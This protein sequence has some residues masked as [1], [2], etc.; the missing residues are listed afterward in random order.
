M[1]VRILTT[2]ASAAAL[3]V[4]IVAIAAGGEREQRPF[5]LVSLP[6]LGT[7]V[8]Q[9][10][11]EAN[12]YGLGFR[13]QEDDSGIRLALYAGGKLRERATI[14]RDKRFGVRPIRPR[15]QRL[16]ISQFTGAGTL[17]ATVSVDFGAR[18]VAAPCRAYL[19]PRTMARVGPRR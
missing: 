6:S 15:R 5:T 8:W 7:V 2:I 12:T 14:I 16:E 18:G 13:P 19:P 10:G 4:G 9:C 11:A 3:G 17:R 1:L